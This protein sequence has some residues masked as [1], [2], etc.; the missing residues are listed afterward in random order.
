MKLTK[1]Y[2]KKT[3]KFSRKL[4]NIGIALATAGGVIIAAPI[5]LPT[6]VISNA[7]YLAV[8]GTVATAV[9]QTVVSDNENDA[10]TENNGNK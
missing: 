1:R 8:A 2:T 5:A 4:R 9:S 3:P 10:E 7:T 6:I